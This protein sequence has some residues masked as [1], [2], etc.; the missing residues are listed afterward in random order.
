MTLTDNDYPLRAIGPHI[1]AR[2]RSSPVLT[3]NDDQLADTVAKSLNAQHLVEKGTR[4]ATEE[5]TAMHWRR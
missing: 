5:H 3:A 1:Y 2:T 4:R